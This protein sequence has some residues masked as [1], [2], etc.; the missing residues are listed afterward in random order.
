MQALQAS[1]EPFQVRMRIQWSG[2]RVRGLTGLVA[3]VLLCAQAAH[4]W[5]HPA[6]SIGPHAG[7]RCAC[8]LSHTAADL[9]RGVPA[10]L[11]TPFVLTAAPDLRLWW[12]H[13][14][15][16]H[17]LAPRPPPALHPSHPQRLL[18]PTM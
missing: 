16:S 4:P 5:M 13:C 3:L 2:V 9:P 12:G 11:L 14:W 15:F 7:T 8:P 18:D 17:S 6:E 1:H 10:W